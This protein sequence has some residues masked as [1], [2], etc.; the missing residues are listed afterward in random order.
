M[1][2]LENIGKYEYVVSAHQCNAVVGYIPS[3]LNSI[4]DKSKVT[5]GCNTGEIAPD[6]ECSMGLRPSD[7]ENCNMG[8][9]VEQECIEKNCTHT[10]TLSR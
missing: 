8:P 4:W 9:V 1:C 7:V 2:R 10:Q 6:E 5:R 3:V